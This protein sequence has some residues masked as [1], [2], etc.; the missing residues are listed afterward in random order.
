METSS[1]TE[2]GP[3]LGR[4]R[5][6]SLVRLHIS[7]PARIQQELERRSTESGMSVS[8]ITTQ[9]LVGAIGQDYRAGK[10]AAE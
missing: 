9:L 5:G 3:A 1:A 7:V 4:Q 6:K 8:A 10:P 2:R